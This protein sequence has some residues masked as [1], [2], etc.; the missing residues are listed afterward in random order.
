MPF[1]TPKNPTFNED[2]KDLAASPFFILQELVLPASYSPKRMTSWFISSITGA[3]SHNFR[4]LAKAPGEVEF[5]VVAEATLRDSIVRDWQFVETIAF[6]TVCDWHAASN[7]NNLKIREYFQGLVERRSSQ[8]SAVRVSV[9][10][11]ET[12]K[13]TVAIPNLKYKNTEPPSPQ[14]VIFSSVAKLISVNYPDTVLICCFEA[15]AAVASIFKDSWKRVHVAITKNLLFI[16]DSATLKISRPFPY[17][18]FTKAKINTSFA[19][20]VCFYSRESVDDAETIIR[21]GDISMEKINLIITMCKFALRNILIATEIR[22]NE[23]EMRKKISADLSGSHLFI[24]KQNSMVNV[25]ESNFTVPNFENQNDIFLFVKTQTLSLQF[26]VPFFKL[27]GQFDVIMYLN[28]EEQANLSV[29]MDYILVSWADSQLILPF[30]EISVIQKSQIPGLMEHLYSVF[31]ASFKIE[32]WTKNNAQY[33]FC[34]YSQSDNLYNLLMSCMHSVVFSTITDSNSL[35]QSLNEMFEIQDES[36]WNETYEKLPCIPLDLNLKNLMIEHMGIPDQMR[37]ILWPFISR[38]VFLKFCYSDYLNLGLCNRVKDE[39]EKDINRSLPEHPAFQSKV[40]QDALRRVLNAF[41]H[42]NPSIGYAQA[43]N[44]VVSHL[45][46]SVNEEQSF[47]ILC[48][49]VEEILP[50]HYSK[51]LVGSVIHQRVFESFLRDYIPELDEHFAKLSLDL[52]T[53]T[54]PWFVALFLSIMP[55]DCAQIVLDF[56]FL[57]KEPFLFKL[58]LG[59]FKVNKPLLL[60]SVDEMSAMIVFKNFFKSLNKRILKNVFEEC[61]EFKITQSDIESK[62]HEHWFS[63]TSKMELDFKRSQIRTFERTSKFKVK[64]LEIFYFYYQRILLLHEQPKSGLNKN[65]FDI[66]M[67]QQGLKYSKL[68]NLMFQYA[69]AKFKKQTL[70]L[71][72]VVALMQEYLKESPNYRFKFLFQLHDVDSDGKLTLEELFDFVQ[73]LLSL[74]MGSQDEI[75]EL[76]SNG[77]HTEMVQYLL[78]FYE[79]ST[80]FCPGNLV[81][82]NAVFMSLMS[83]PYLVNKLGLF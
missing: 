73:S 23:F 34:A 61:F 17:I 81:T 67:Q 69:T 21:I 27:L 9:E 54:I 37:K 24:S 50:E 83:V 1:I 68:S 39:I 82:Q 53:V 66:F 79:T 3:L 78:D 26:C 57:E 43:M 60:L 12:Q 25:S 74:L 4:I 8:D 55:M 31:T 6:P 58:A 56:F 64:E 2:W 49:I 5:L 44:L 47:L 38:S 30:K 42:K 59:I 46:L 40:G 19:S 77:P 62:R 20:E 41:A 63:V 45:L 15:R 76:K 7:L 51:T 32:I 70:D 52:S 80:H 22:T 16:T 35:K 36:N 29:T 65:G 33:S 11:I 14:D 48:K 71:S 13:L 72:S 28:Q 75:T 18:S 10:S